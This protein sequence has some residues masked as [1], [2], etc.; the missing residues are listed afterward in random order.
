MSTFK[1]RDGSTKPMII[2]SPVSHLSHG[3]MAEQ[4]ARHGSKAN[5]ARD[6]RRGKDVQPVQVHG[7][8]V[9]KQTD[10]MNVGGMGHSLPLKDGGQLGVNPLMVKPPLPKRTAPPRIA[11]VLG[12]KIRDSASHV[13][14]PQ[15]IDHVPDCP[16][17]G[18]LPG[19]HKY[20]KC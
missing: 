17:I 13:G 11:T 7:G 9:R 12:Q 3:F 8:M 10:V 19:G 15:T 16:N 18:S 5:I 6:A 1:N 2:N 14:G 20:G 4:P